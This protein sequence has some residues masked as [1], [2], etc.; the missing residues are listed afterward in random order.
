MSTDITIFGF[1]PV[2]RETTRRLLA[3]GVSVRV[4]Q[5]HAP[6]DLPQGISFIACDVLDA[7]AVGRATKG[8][9]QIVVAVGFPYDGDFWRVAWPRAMTN[10]I[11]ACEETRARMVFVDNLYMYGPQNPPLREDMPLVPFGVKPAVRVEATRIWMAAAEARRTRVAALRASDF[12]GPG[13]TLSHLGANAFGAIAERKRAFLLAP[14][15]TQ[16]D[17]A[18]VPD[19]ARGVVTLLDAPDDAY[20]HAWHL[21]CASTRTPR[22]ILSLGAQALGHAP[23]I[24]ALPLALLPVLGLGSPLLR[25]MTEMRF[26]WDRPYRVDAR[27]FSSRFWSDATPLVIGAAATARS[28]ASDA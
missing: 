13:V 14:P 2:G 7:E 28:F 18:Y 26:L 15:D 21:P 12:Y 16:H 23:S 1:G 17:F 19:V 24:F 5:R 9:Q 22:E 6:P 3:Q 20:G 11:T 25:E 8:A 10:F 27:K 4:A